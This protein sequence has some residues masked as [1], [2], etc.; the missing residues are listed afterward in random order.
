MARFKLG[1]PP[2]VESWIGFDFEP[3][4]DKVAWDGQLA[5]QLVDSLVE[6]FPKKD[7]RYRSEVQV[8]AAGPGQLPMP[9]AIQHKLEMVRVQ[10]ETATRVLQIG[11]DRLFLH[12]LKGEEEWPGFESLMEETLGMVDRYT[13]VFQPSRIRLSDAPRCGH[14]QDTA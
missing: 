11:D 14:S 7:L 12:Q 8:V 1:R 4:A 3:K 2:I 9:K 5:N 13:E 6:D 10:N